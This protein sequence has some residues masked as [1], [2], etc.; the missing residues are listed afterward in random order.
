MNEKLAIDREFRSL[1]P[2]LTEEELA[3]LEESLKREGCRDPL[4]TWQGKILDGHHRYRI[5]KK[6]KI[7][8]S[9]IELDLPR[10]DSAK[11]WII[12][13]QF[14][15]RNL[16]IFQ[17]CE[18]ALELKPLIEEK[19][20][21]KQRQAGKEKL[22]QNSAKAIDTREELAAIAGVSHD[23]VR[24]AWDIKI[25]GGPEAMERLRRG[26]TSINLE[27][28]MIGT[29]DEKFLKLKTEGAILTQEWKEIETECDRVEALGHP[30]KETTEVLKK[31]VAFH[32]KC[33]E[34]AFRGSVLVIENEA[35]MGKA[36]N[37]MQEE[38]P[39]F[40]DKWIKSNAKGQQ[41]MLEGRKEEMEM[42]LKKAQR[43]FIEAVNHEITLTRMKLR[44]DLWREAEKTYMKEDIDASDTLR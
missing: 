41:E 36:L 20:R 6:Y 21:E 11:E 24:K 1:I 16:T 22:P 44:P 10:K 12:R 2:A 25:H 5:C 9:T 26:E 30:E 37:E 35:K 42:R 33:Y 32:K 8:F 29:D 31:I 34:A 17:R 18:L 15:R 43:E 13:N 38:D 27:H 28:K 40:Y 7:K 19:A 3:L 39:E 14:G 23:T 4:V